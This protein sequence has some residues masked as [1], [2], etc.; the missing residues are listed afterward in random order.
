MSSCESRPCLDESMCAI[1]VRV[2]MVSSKL[3][4]SFISRMCDPPFPPP[5]DWRCLVKESRSDELPPIAVFPP[6]VVGTATGAVVTYATPVADAS[7]LPEQS[8]ERFE[9]CP[10]VPVLIVIGPDIVLAVGADGVIVAGTVEP[11]VDVTGGVS[12]AHRLR[13]ASESISDA[14]VGGVGRLGGE[15]GSGNSEA[16]VS[17]GT[18]K[19]DILLMSLLFQA[20]VHK[21][22]VTV[23]SDF[24]IYGG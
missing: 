6:P 10:S 11:A 13:M 15:E 12:L 2:S 16:D 3:L 22:R 5:D 19:H 8:P 7:I 14:A 17:G 23:K 24:T 21:I 4:Q 20:S 9:M 18:A 1:D